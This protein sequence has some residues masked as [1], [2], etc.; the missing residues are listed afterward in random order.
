MRLR[1]KGWLRVRPTPGIARRKYQIMNTSTEKIPMSRFLSFGSFSSLFLCLL[2][3]VLVSCSTGSSSGDNTSIE[4]DS[5]SQPS[6]PTYTCGDLPNSF[7]SYSVAVS[8]VRAATFPI[9]QS[10]NT[11]RSS[12]IDGAEYYSCDGRTGYFILLTNG[13][14]YIHEGVPFS[15]W[16]GFKQA[17]SF[18]S[19]YNR[20]LKGIY[21]MRFWIH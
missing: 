8:L 12:W 10:A 5:Y 2:A 15:V 16:R 3:S 19:F 11:S 7:S 17:G 13:R 18:G 4:R 20:E 6:I 21:R 9:E 14:T 1:L